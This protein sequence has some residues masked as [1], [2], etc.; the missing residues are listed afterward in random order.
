VGD[1]LRSQSTQNNVKT[2]PVNPELLRLKVTS[3]AGMT[4]AEVAGLVSI[5]NACG[6]VLLEPAVDPEDGLAAYRMLDRLFGRSVNHDHTDDRGVVEINPARPMSI[7]VADPE[8][9]HLPHTD[10]AYTEQ[11]ARIMTLQCREAAPSGK[12]ES[13]L[14]SGLDLLGALTC[15]E[16]GALMR[17]NMVT[18]GRRP[19]ADGS[20]M[21]CSAIPMFWVSPESGRV[22]LRWRCNDGCVKDIDVEARSAYHRMDAIARNELYQLVVHL[23][24]KEVLLVDNRAIAHGRRPFE[25][26]E[27]RILWRK[28]YYGDGELA[29]HLRIGMCD[30]HS[31]FIDHV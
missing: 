20:W 31:R 10:D 21:K 26:H 15:E 12:G 22:Q 19:A 27:P 1:I 6:A 11:P 3:I 5:M 24:P 14:V 13:V 4:Q 8:K 18:M 29:K 9:S 23:A 17:P 2:L 25:V 16:L 7:N 30:A 28:N